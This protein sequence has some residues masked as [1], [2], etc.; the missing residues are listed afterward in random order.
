MRH[1]EY[2]PLGQN[3]MGGSIFYWE[4]EPGTHFQKLVVQHKSW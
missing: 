4:Y 2:G 1:I 3:T